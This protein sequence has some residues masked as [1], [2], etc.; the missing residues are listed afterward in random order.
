MGQASND[1]NR[2][3]DGVFPA[4][5]RWRAWPP[6]A[7]VAIVLGGRRIALWRRQWR[8]FGLAPI[9]LA[10]A[11]IFASNDEMAA[12]VL[13]VAHSLGI[14]IPDELSVAGFDD[15]PLASQVWPALTT[16]RQP[17]SAIDLQRRPA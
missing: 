12:G 2:V 1:G 16:I 7:L 13:A 3:L 17:I 6:A 11:A 4:P 9:G 14:G 8:W 5:Q 15:V 10:L